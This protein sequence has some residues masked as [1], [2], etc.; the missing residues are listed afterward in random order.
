M[1]DPLRKPVSGEEFVPSAKQ[2]GL[3][4]DA[5]NSIRNQSRETKQ[6]K[7]E[8]DR[9]V[10]LVRNDTGA[11]LTAERPI[12]AL[13]DPLYNPSNRLNAA[14]ERPVFSGIVPQFGLSPEKKWVVLSGPCADG[15]I[16]KAVATGVA[17]VKISVTDSA[18]T[19]CT[20][21]DGE[22]SRLISSDSGEAEILWKEEGPGVKWAVVRLPTI[23]NRIFRKARIEIGEMLVENLRSTYDFRQFFQSIVG[24]SA[25]IQHNIG[26]AGTNEKNHWVDSP[27]VPIT[28]Y[29][30]GG[31]R[32][33][34]F[35]D[36][37]ID[38]WYSPDSDRWQAASG[39]HTVIAARSGAEAITS[40][41]GGTA[42]VSTPR[43][44]NQQIA[45]A[46]AT[47]DIPPD[48]TF[49]AIWVS[50]DVQQ[51]I[52]NPSGDP[53]PIPYVDDAFSP[54]YWV[55]I[56]SEDI[57]LGCGLKWENILNES[58]EVIGRELAFDGA[59]V[60]GD[61]LEWD[62]EYCKMSTGPID[63]TDLTDSIP[64]CDTICTRLDAIEARL[65]TIENT[66]LDLI[67]CCEENRA[68]C[69][70]MRICCDYN[71]AC[72]KYNTYC[73]EYLDARVDYCCGPGKPGPGD[74]GGGPDCG[75]CVWEWND[76]GEAPILVES[77]GGG[78]ACDC[79]PPTVFDVP[80]IYFTDCF[81]TSDG[82]CDEWPTTFNIT[83]VGCGD[84]NNAVAMNGGDG[85]YV[86]SITVDDGGTEWTFTL[87]AS[88]NCPGP[89][90][91]N[92]TLRVQAV[93]ANT[94]DETVGVSGSCSPFT[95]DVDVA[96]DP[97]PCAC[98]NVTI[99]HQN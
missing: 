80:G 85:F 32:G 17:W 75:R 19:R 89:G 64:C 76:A 53:E 49:V 56:A 94:C 58:Q 88:E 93:G 98:G 4:I 74:E 20:T 9:G 97:V 50:P 7:A 60:A 95:F 51:M 35:Q 46:F 55:G 40:D 3:F 18:H 11:D 43:G 63:C 22:T 78:P 8:L 25:R 48:T 73:C 16:S 34:A 44:A 67:E 15:A 38:V 59:A 14:Y 5:A 33:V 10:V 27:D 91:W 86:G 92:G 1:T 29:P 12:L 41:G 31:F 45:I 2:F 68:C 65:D 37:L 99:T 6:L 57:E 52:I 77:C 61:G 81:S 47:R 23:E 72:C 71:T 21:E 90:D 36:S 79:D 42:E 54:G 39:G 70:E 66:I 26:E 84:L 24:A 28:V 83:A 62:E 82:C 13:D 69:E 96:D 30:D 87:T